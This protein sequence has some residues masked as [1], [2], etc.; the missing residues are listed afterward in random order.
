MHAAEPLVVLYLP[1]VQAVHGPPSGPV[2]PALQAVDT[3]AVPPLGEVEPAGHVRH[4]LA[5]A[6][7]AYAPTRQFVQTVALLPPV[8]PEYVPAEHAKQPTAS[9][10]AEYVPGGQ[11][12][13]P[14]PDT[15]VPAAQAEPTHTLDPAIDVL[16]ASHA[17]HAPADVSEYVFT[18]QFVQVDAYIAP[19]EP[20]Y[21]PAVHAVHVLCVLAPVAPEYFP[22]AQEIH[23]FELL[24][25]EQ[26]GAH[27][28]QASHAPSG[29][30]N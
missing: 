27:S 10:T 3:Q 20:E 4:A 15:Y 22:T 18:G 25:F 8:T 17:V 19:V 6:A 30:Q 28:Q 21:F 14:P 2:N 1:A 9:T 29:L 5:P 23:M 24:G 12:V 7:G 26:Y 16:P 11:F 13:Q